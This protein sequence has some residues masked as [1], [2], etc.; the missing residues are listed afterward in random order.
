MH[1]ATAPS[2]VSQRHSA[3][4]R[5]NGDPTANHCHRNSTL[6]SHTHERSIAPHVQQYG[7]APS[8]GTALNLLAALG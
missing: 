5:P 8:T 2:P 7:T 3:V 4:T 6:H 1:N